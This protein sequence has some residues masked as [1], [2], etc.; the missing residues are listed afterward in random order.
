ME[1]AMEYR[2]NT[3]PNLDSILFRIIKGRLLFST[4]DLRLYIEDPN[5][6]MMFY[7]SEIYDKTYEE[8]YGQEVLME[9]EMRE[10]MESQSLWSPFEDEEL[11]SLEVENEK[12]KL[13]AFL[14]FG[15]KNEL[16]KYKTKIF[17]NNSRQNELYK[18]R[19]QFF[20]MTCEGI[21]TQAQWNWII[22][23]STY[24]MAGK[25]HILDE[26]GIGAAFGYYE[27]NL[28]SMGELKRVARFSVWRQM[29][30]IG[31]KVG[32]PLERPVTEYTKNQLSLC[33]LS[34]MYD[35]VYES[36]DCPSD[37]IIEDDD[38][39][40]GWFIHQK[41]KSKEQNKESV[42]DNK[43]GKLKNCQEIYIIPSSPQ[44][45]D[46]IN[47]FNSPKAQLYKNHRK[48]IIDQQGFI[49]NDAELRDMRK[50]L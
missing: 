44:D 16:R 15:I 30:A 9:H 26:A 33:S 50:N 31:K 6:E 11:K 43:L 1:V 36:V 4:G 23:N 24:D 8:C 10:W 29:W 35:G 21:A 19:N 34:A 46:D 18:R 3:G 45:I 28:L 38:C 13:G 17:L 27:R 49:K 25:K 14:N 2:D 39:L 42:I 32:R 20:H 5:S 12:L 47:S 41:E 48:N 40:D 37:E 7:S 22:E